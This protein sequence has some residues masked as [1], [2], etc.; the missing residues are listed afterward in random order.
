MNGIT[1]SLETVANVQIAPI[2]IAKEFWEISP[3]HR[4]SSR[5]KIAASSSVQSLTATQATLWLEE[6]EDV[7]YNR[8]IRTK[9]CPLQ[10]K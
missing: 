3:I 10:S 7:L 6:A 8:R 1:A 5:D 9:I 4:A 2:P